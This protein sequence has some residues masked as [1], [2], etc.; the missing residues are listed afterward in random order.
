MKLMK[1]PAAAQ[2]LSEL[3][4]IPVP[5]GTMR[6]WARDGKVPIAGRTPGGQ[7]LFEEADLKEL[8]H[9]GG[10]RPTEEAFDER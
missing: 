4:G 2:Y 10:R 9:A 6:Q 8:H 3:W 5:V 1:L 7:Y